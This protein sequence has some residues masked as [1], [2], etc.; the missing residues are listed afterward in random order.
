MS[1]VSF[2]LAGFQVTLI[3]RFWVTP[4]AAK[5]GAR[6]RVQGY[7]IFIPGHDRLSTA[8]NVDIIAVGVNAIGLTVGSRNGN[9]VK[10]AG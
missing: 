9:C 7:P 4:E 5:G 1:W 6:A 3:G 10:I 2:S 8:I